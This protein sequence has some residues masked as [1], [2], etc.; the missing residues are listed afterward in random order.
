[1]RAHLLIACLIEADKTTRQLTDKQI[2]KR[3]KARGGFNK[4]AVDSLAVELSRARKWQKSKEGQAWI[5]HEARR[6]AAVTASA[7][8]EK[9][10][11]PI[12]G[13]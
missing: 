11:D 7:P 13:R 8:N 10:S 12:G 6:V 5:E 4:W 2:L 3:V 1:M 9:A